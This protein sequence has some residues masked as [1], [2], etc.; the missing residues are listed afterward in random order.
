[1]MIPNSVTAVYLNHALWADADLAT[2]TGQLDSWG[3][4]PSW[5]EFGLTRQ[6]GRPAMTF[7]LQP[8][9]NV[10]LVSV[11]EKVF[12]DPLG[13]FNGAWPLFYDGNGNWP[14]LEGSLDDYLRWQGLIIEPNAD[15]APHRVRAVDY[16]W[17][18]NKCNFRTPPLPGSKVIGSEFTYSGQP[19]VLIAEHIIRTCTTQYQRANVGGREMDP[20]SLTATIPTYEEYSGRGLSVKIAW[21]GLRVDELDNDLYLDT[22]D[23]LG[24]TVPA[25]ELYTPCA[26]TPSIA[27]DTHRAFVPDPITVS[28]VSLLVALQNVLDSVGNFRMRID[29]FNVVRFELSVL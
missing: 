23:M 7:L 10:K 13:K 29:Q 1:M 14:P 27:N 22:Y 19:W 26:A 8:L 3:V 6:P 20:G 11:P 24:T 12:R 25:G 15:P 5:I 9:A 21:A 17:C 28:N 16:R 2:L 4:E 18:I